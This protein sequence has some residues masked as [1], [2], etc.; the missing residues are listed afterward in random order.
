[1]PWGVSESGYYK[2][3]AQL[4]YQ[5]RAFGVPG[6]GFKRGLADDLVIAPYASAL[7]LMVAPQAACANLRGLA[8]AGVLGPYGFYEA[9][10]YTAAHPPA[11]GGRVVVR[12]VM[13]HH[14][15]MTLLAIAYALLGRPMQRR[16]AAAPSFR[17][18]E[19]LLQER[20]PRA[21][22]VFPHPVEVASATAAGDVEHDLRVFTTP[23]TPAP[24]VHLLSN[25]HYHVALTNAGGGY[26]RWRDLAVTR[27]HEDPTRDCWGTFG[28]LRDVTAGA[29]GDRAAAFWSIAHQPTL[30]RSTRYEA[31]FSQGRAEFR[32]LDH[33]ID[34]HVEISI[35]P[36]DD[37]E[38]RRITVSNRGRTPRAIELTS[39]AEVVIAHAAA[40]AAHPAFSN[41]FVQTEL[42]PAHQAI[43]CTRRPRSG[44][45]RPPWM[46]HVMAVHGAV[47][48]E[49]SY[50]TSRAAFI[51]RGRSVRDPIAMHQA[52]LTGSAGAVL[53]PIVA[54]RN[55]VVLAPD[56]TA[57]I[58]VV[59]GM[60]ETR[61]AAL[62]LI[63]K[64]RDR[65]AADR[66][67]ELSWTHS[68]VVQRRLEATSAETHLYER[69]ASNV[70]YANPTLRA[71][72]S[73][74]ARNRGGQS[75]LWAYGISGDLPIVLVRIADVA[76]INLVRQL[77]K[78]PG[79]GAGAS[80]PA[81][82]KPGD[83]R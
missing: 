81:S 46:I 3:D 74:L 45:E 44:D 16:F 79:P 59:T 48:G 21:P 1:V 49:P 64:Y 36:E 17:A 83:S 20:V 29:P 8:R 53:D 23:N 11:D 78:Y 52:T 50:E 73:L 14:Q 56:E 18:T 80:S 32:R 58:H 51:G 26:S 15:G 62:G 61:D 12:S 66:V 6:L 10:D 55:R 37:I 31:I 69:L 35:S 75:G 60:A 68:Q 40:D 4:N 19:L 82:D 41:L 7:A 76:H 57:R 39:F 24:E 9:V 2:T 22:A 13:A 33:D 70:L 54:I 28:Y 72:S 67:F 42:V 47:D 5:Y 34:T 71:P 65:H 77:V 38:L 43:L 30:V 63:E 27:W 25:G